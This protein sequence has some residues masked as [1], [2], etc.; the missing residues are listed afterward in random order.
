MGT[1]IRLNKLARLGVVAAIADINNRI[2]TL[3]EKFPDRKHFEQ[4]AGR[5][6]TDAEVTLAAIS[7]H[8]VLVLALALGDS[9]G[10]QQIADRLGMPRSTIAW[11]MRRAAM[12]LRAA[13]MTVKLPG[14]GRPSRPGHRVESVDPT[15]MNRLTIHDRGGV[16]VAS[17]TDRSEHDEADILKATA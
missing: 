11:Q 7:R 12:K 8:E 2:A 9:M 5:P 15:T 14:R 1:K 13:G 17:W 4:K 3:E 10:Q 6:L 16:N